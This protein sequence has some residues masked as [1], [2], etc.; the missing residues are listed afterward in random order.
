MK[1][2]FDAEYFAME[3]Q[4]HIDLLGI[5]YLANSSGLEADTIQDILD[6]RAPNVDDFCALVNAI[7]SAQQF[8]DY[9]VCGE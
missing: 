1:L 7:D 5:G 9:F 4:E 2:E 8:Q 3:L 6:G